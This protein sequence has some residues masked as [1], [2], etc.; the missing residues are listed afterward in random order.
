MFLCLGQPVFLDIYVKAVLNAKEKPMKVLS[1]SFQPLFT[2]MSHEDFQSIVLPSF[3]KML[4]RNPEIVMESV[5]ILLKSLSLDLSKYAIEILLV[6]LS[7]VRHA[8]EGR[9]VGALTVVGCLSQKSSNPDTI[10]AMF[11]ASKA[12]IEGLRKFFSLA[13]L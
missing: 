2:H 3:V 8:D 10:E 12:V 6:V 4:K 5:G 9:R 1:E 11:S 13:S 7:Q